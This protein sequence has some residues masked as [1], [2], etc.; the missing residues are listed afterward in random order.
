[1]GIFAWIIFGL[2]AGALAQ[3]IMPGDDPGGRGFM[4]WLIT[5]VVGIVGAIVGGLVG[6]A[7]GLGGVS[8]FNL[9]SFLIAV[10]GALL[11]LFVWRMVARQSSRGRHSLA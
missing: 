6:A 7:V 9:G 11:V 4:G 3:V 8:G 10:A 2:L 1:M 5:I